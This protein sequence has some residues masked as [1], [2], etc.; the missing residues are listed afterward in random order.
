MKIRVG[1]WLAITLVNLA[2]S[3]ILISSSIQSE[4]VSDGKMEFSF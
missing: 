4:E 1:F 2:I 3:C